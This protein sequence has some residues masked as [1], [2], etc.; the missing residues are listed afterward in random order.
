[1]E[2]RQRHFGGRHEIQVPVAGDLEEVLLEL[3]QVPGAGER[4][5]VHEKRRLHLRV[6]VLARVEVEHE[7]DERARRGARPAPMQHR[8][9]R[10]GDL[11]ARARSRGCRAPAPRS[12]C[13]FGSKSNAGGVPTR[14]TSRLSSA[15]LPT[16]TVACGRLGIPSR[17]AW[18][19]DSCAS[20]S[21]SSCL[22]PGSGARLAA[23]TLDGSCP[24]FSGGRPPRRRHSALA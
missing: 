7:V 24:S 17:A 11:R 1:M 9:P 5:R 2:I 16:G 22:I 14:R 6:A 13:A 19:S 10:A 21:A 12:Q 4:R 20:T 23:N 8:E 3:R 18:R 15:L